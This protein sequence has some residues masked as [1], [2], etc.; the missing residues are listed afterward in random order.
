MPQ[1]DMEGMS[2]LNLSEHEAMRFWMRLLYLK[3]QIKGLDNSDNQLCEMKRLLH[4]FQ[5]IDE[6]NENG[7]MTFMGEDGKMVTAC[8]GEIMQWIF[9]DD[10][11][12]R[13]K[14][15]IKRLIKVSKEE[16]RTDTS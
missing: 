4:L 15:L 5:F 6:G 8:R 1:A 9:K 7:W 12:V 14:Q 10:R 2:L 13:A 3:E 11:G 16:K